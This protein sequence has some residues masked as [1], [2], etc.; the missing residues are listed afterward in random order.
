MMPLEMSETVKNL[1]IQISS[2][3]ISSS[4]ITKPYSI[5]KLYAISNV[6]RMDLIIVIAC[7]FTFNNVCSVVQD[8]DSQ[9]ARFHLK[10]T[11]KD[12]SLKIIRK[13]PQVRFD[14][15][16]WSDVR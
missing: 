13:Y 4:S 9:S 8:A 1:K 15:I 2:L 10:V 14:S 11:L 3:H 7:S 6:K 16:I 5:V 12:I